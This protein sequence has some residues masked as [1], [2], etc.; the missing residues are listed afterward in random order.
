MK[1][2]LIIAHGSRRVVSNQEIYQLTQQLQNMPSQFQQI[3]CAFLELA[4][5]SIPDALEQCV[6]AGA[7]EIVILP[8]FLS[9]GRHVAEDIPEA[10]HSKQL[11]YPEVK[12]T[13][14]PYIG[15]APQLVE[16][17]LKLAQSTI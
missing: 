16:L 17:L 14:A 3:R 11:V 13:L 4:E 9:A 12:M 7:Q 15:Q 6:Q 5:P 8:Y 2:L 10:V 1:F